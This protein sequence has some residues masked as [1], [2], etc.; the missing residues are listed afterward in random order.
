MSTPLGFDVAAARAACGDAEPVA[1][2]V[3]PVASLH[4]RLNGNRKAD[5][6]AIPPA[7]LNGGANSMSMAHLSFRGSA[8]PLA[9]PFAGEPTPTRGLLRPSP[10]D[11]SSNFFKARRR[12]RLPPRRGQAGAPDVLER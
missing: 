1:S 10:A 3:R 6:S 12:E 7:R 8:S 9:S 5:A 2:G 11:A 4:P